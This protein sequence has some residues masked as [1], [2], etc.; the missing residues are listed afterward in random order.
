[1][2]HAESRLH[3]A[4]VAVLDH[5][6]AIWPQEQASRL[7][8]AGWQR[9]RRHRM[10]GNARLKSGAE[11]HRDND[12]NPDA[13]D[14]TEEHQEQNRHEFPSIHPTSTYDSV[15]VIQWE[16]LLRG[17]AAGVVSAGGD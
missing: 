10:Q 12:A 8:S 17:T 7:L 13:Q 4:P 6:P 14:K 2:M 3:C 11:A 15:R 1:M 9:A 5:Q 16:V